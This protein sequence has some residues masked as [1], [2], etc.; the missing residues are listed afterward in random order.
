MKHEGGISDDEIRPFLAKIHSA[1]DGCVSDT[2]MR[3]AVVK[4]MTNTVHGFIGDVE[5]SKS[6]DMEEEVHVQ[7]FPEWYQQII[8]KWEM[9]HASSNRTK[10]VEL[11]KK[12]QEKIKHL[13][14]EI[15]RAQE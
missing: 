7:S 15:R 9:I 10:I 11:L 2:A 12:H 8:G 13:V 6:E 4:A 1:I 5:A 14:A 3:D